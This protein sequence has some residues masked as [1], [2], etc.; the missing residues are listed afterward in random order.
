MKETKRNGKVLKHILTMTDLT[1]KEIEVMI[2]E[3]I[4]MKKELREGKSH[5]VLEGKSLGMVFEKDS[6]RTR[7]SFEV[8]MTQLGG[9]AVFFSPTDLKLGARETVADTA[10]VLSRF[11]DALM[12]RT[13]SHDIIEELAENASIPIINGLTDEH[14]PMQV[15]S[16]L[17]TIYEK[18]GH[19]EGIK[20]AYLGDGNNNITHSLLE[21]CALMGMDVSVATPKGYEP[22]P[23]VIE[24]AEKIASQTKTT[25]ELTHDPKKA[26]KNADVVMTD[27]WTKLGAT[28]DVSAN[29]RIFKDYQ[30]NEELVAEAK[31]DYIFMHCLP[32]HRGEEVS[33]EILDSEHSVVYD[34]TENRLHIQKAALVELIK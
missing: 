8:G 24:R 13:F 5:R 22:L 23:V 2:L 21:G 10:Q 28:A 11:V 9:H 12:V 14:F 33:A 26:V 1:A 20:L 3:A 19:L 7:L 6:T 29:M 15:L 34:G 16:D 32:A 17:M 27:G 31:D 30:V 25:I 4:R 18:K